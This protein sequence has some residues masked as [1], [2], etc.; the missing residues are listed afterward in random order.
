MYLLCMYCGTCWMIGAVWL[1]LSKDESASDACSAQ[2]SALPGRIV[3]ALAA[4]LLAPFFC[5]CLYKVTMSFFRLWRF[6]NTYTEPELTPVNSLT[7]GESVQNLFAK[8]TAELFPFHFRLVTDCIFRSEPV[9]IV[10]RYLLSDDQKTI[11]VLCVA[12]TEFDAE[13]ET[14]YWSLLSVNEDGTYF[15]SC[16][17]PEDTFDEKPA[18][19]DQVVM[20]LTGES[21]FEELLQRHEQ[22]VEAISVPVLCWRPE[23][24]LEVSRYGYRKVAAWKFRTGQINT[25]PPEAILPSRDPA[26]EHDSMTEKEGD[27]ALELVG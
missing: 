18:K 15:E 5:I 1:L 16:T 10:S 4:P 24:V 21:N 2:T 25:E 20:T 22:A 7:F 13:T 12:E 27:R 26:V 19:D 17:A 8:G 14:C 6:E 3:A 23:D 11:A 9:Y